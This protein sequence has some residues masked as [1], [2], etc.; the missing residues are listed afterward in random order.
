MDADGTGL[1]LSVSMARSKARPR[2]TGVVV[3]GSNPATLAQLSAYF[4]DTGVKSYARGS[5]T[6]LAELRP[7]AQV[8]VLFPDDFRKP[9]VS[10]YLRDLGSRRPELTFI[11]ITQS[12]AEYQALTAANGKAL[13][14][15]VLPKPSFGWTILD[16]IRD[17]LAS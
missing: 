14:A 2:E 7:A 11:I 5:L 6:P 15:H 9:Q 4:A 8:V 1:A 16:A 3:L 10:A 17:A 12:P 13:R